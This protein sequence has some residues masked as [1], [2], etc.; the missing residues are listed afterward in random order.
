MAV[1]E[2]SAFSGLLSGWM[3]RCQQNALY[4]IRMEIAHVSC[5]CLRDGGTLEGPPFGCPVSGIQ[6]TS[7]AKPGR[8]F[9]LRRQQEGKGDN[10]ASGARES[11]RKHMNLTVKLRSSSEKDKRSIYDWE[12]EDTP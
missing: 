12:K 10:K 9:F 7:A 11:E 5:S 4:I 8:R 1:R 3:K 2:A 6:R